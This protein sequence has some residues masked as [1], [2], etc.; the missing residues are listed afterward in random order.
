[1]FGSFV[2]G[3]DLLGLEETGLSVSVF[4]AIE[5]TEEFVDADI[6]NVD[7]VVTIDETY[8]GGF[9]YSNTVPDTVI[10]GEQVVVSDIY[11]ES[12]SDVVNVGESYVSN[13]PNIQITVS[14]PVSVTEQYISSN[15]NIQISFIETV[16]TPSENNIV[17][18]PNIPV[19]VLEQIIEVFDVGFSNDPNILDEITEDII[20]YFNEII[21]THFPITSDFSVD[22]VNVLEEYIVSDPNIIETLSDAVE[23]DESIIDGGVQTIQVD[24]HVIVD[25][26]NIVSDPNIA[27]SFDELI[28]IDELLISNDTNILISVDDTVPITDGNVSNDTNIQ[29]QLIEHVDDYVAESIFQITDR[30]EIIEAISVTESNDWVFE[31]PPEVS[32]DSI[33][34]LELI[35]TEPYDHNVTVSDI[36]HI[37]EQQIIGGYEHVSDAIVIDEAFQISEYDVINVNETIDF[38]VSLSVRDT[39]VIV[40]DPQPGHESSA[41]NSDN[42]V[43][44]EYIIDEIID[45]TLHRRYAPQ[46][47]G[48]PAT[49]PAITQAQTVTIQFGAHSLTLRAPEFGNV[50]RRHTAR[51]MRKSR[52]GDVR[53]GYN[54]EWPRYDVLGLQFILVKGLELATF[55]TI[56]EESLGQNVTFTDHEGRTWEGMLL[57]PSIV[58]NRRDSFD[59]SFELE[60]DLV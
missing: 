2:L 20:I 50:R 56:Y 35:T 48:L 33:Y 37:Q 46:G 55:E 14:D 8:S 32:S 36:V 38:T 12:A 6:Q 42:A 16:P 44:T 13:H 60:G 18:N 25:E 22:T 45:S 41:S 21:H 15:P 19:N 23:I 43:V 3:V 47:P 51:I 7:D 34:I 10:V 26:T 40:E 59:L 24:D 57:N 4:D 17:S 5:I 9:E 58:E 27:V 31:Y 28:L 39:V 52:G 11:H 53:T 30:E 54:P 29:I 49:P 1:M